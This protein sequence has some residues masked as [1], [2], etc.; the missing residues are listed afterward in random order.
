MV[1]LDSHM[2]VSLG[3]SADRLCNRPARSTGRSSFGKP[4]ADT[5]GTA[6]R[7]GRAAALEI[8]ARLIARMLVA[9][10]NRA[11]HLRSAPRSRRAICPDRRSF[12]YASPVPLAELRGEPGTS[13]QEHAARTAQGGRRRERGLERDDVS[14]KILGQH[15]RGCFAASAERR[16]NRRRLAPG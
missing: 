13:R 8:L 14:S 3:H 4:R 15:G 16:Q 1:L 10:A 6:R 9:A 2:T 11:S 7:G 5:L 12:I